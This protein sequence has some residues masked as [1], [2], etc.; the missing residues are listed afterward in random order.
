MSIEAKKEYLREIKERYS[1]SDKKE[2]QRILD[3]FC[4]TCSYNR[5]YAIRLLKKVRSKGLAKKKP[6]RPKV[7]TKEGLVKFLEKLWLSLNLGCSRKIQAAIPLWLRYSPIKLSEEEKTLLKKI[8]FSSID[9]L[10]RGKRRR[11]KKLGLTTTKPGS[12]LRKQIPV[13]TNQWDQKVPGFIEADTVAHCGGSVAGQ[14]VY[15]LQIVDIALGW[16]EARAAWGKGERGVFMALRDI[17]DS[18]PFRIKGFDSDNGNEFLN[19]HLLRYFLNKKPMVQFTRSRPYQKNDNAHIEEK[20]WTNIRQYLGYQRFDDESVVSL[21]NDLYT[22]EW[23]M[24]FNYFVPSMKLIEKHR[25]GAHIKKIHDKPRTPF[26][27]LCDSGI[28]KPGKIREMR[29]LAEAIDPFD[30]QERMKNKILAILKIAS[31]QIIGE[32]VA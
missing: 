28:M 18:L 25:E 8:S 29:K 11:Y 15:S 30:L 26:E 7:Y 27:R 21:L 31:H 23:T 13:S 4:A 2:K 14:F 5:K 10:L 22:N 1:K 3:E 20:N 16:T 19:R 32:K 24:F 12:L 6:G 9:R 17:E